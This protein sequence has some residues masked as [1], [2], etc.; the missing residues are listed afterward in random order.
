MPGWGVSMHS[1][2]ERGCL[3]IGPAARAMDSLGDKPRQARDQFVQRLL[4]RTLPN[5]SN[6]TKSSQIKSKHANTSQ[7]KP[8]QTK[9]PNQGK[10]RQGNSS[11]NQR[12][13]VKSSPSHIKSRPNQLSH[14]MCLLPRPLPGL[15][16][17][18]RV[19]SGE[20]RVVSGER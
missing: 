1:V 10:Q 19:A 18:W 4:A 13:Q 8:D 12:G 11:Q 6:Q 5:K 2:L 7:V 14:V 16:G 3:Y 17:Q 9:P 15:I 20:W